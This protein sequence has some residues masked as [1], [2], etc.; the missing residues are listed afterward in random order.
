MDCRMLAAL[1]LVENSSVILVAAMLVSPMMV[2]T[3]YL[4]FLCFN[5]NLSVGRVREWMVCP[6]RQFWP[7]VLV[8]KYSTGACTPHLKLMGVFQKKS[9][10]PLWR[11][12]RSGSIISSLTLV[13]GFRCSLNYCSLYF[14]SFFVKLVECIVIFL[15]LPTISCV[16]YLLVFFL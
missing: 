12:W 5:L 4:H 1:G 6:L 15:K 13:L 7:E 2:I 10:S 14:L 8:G 16:L 11:L 9:T 3:K